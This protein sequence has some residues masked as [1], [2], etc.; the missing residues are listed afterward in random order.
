MALDDPLPDGS[1]LCIEC[2]LC[3][4]GALHNAA[5]LL[6][7]EVPLAFALGMKVTQSSQEAEFALPCH[8]L[9]D[10]CC[11]VYADRPSPCRNYKCRL[12]QS[13]DSGERS[14]EEC[15][16][17]VSK[18]RS[19]LSELEAVLPVGMT[20]PEA[21]GVA[22][23]KA[24]KNDAGMPENAK[25]KLHAFALNVYLEKYFRNDYESSF[26]EISSLEEG[27]G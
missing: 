13:L 6:P 1:R 26:L 11:S 14:L 24:V 25:I 16:E 17:K 2:G 3:C 27:G 19:L 8:L 4:D 20:L 12:L 7:E 18:A 10:R 23:S 21:R 5:T 9:K 15:L 22:A